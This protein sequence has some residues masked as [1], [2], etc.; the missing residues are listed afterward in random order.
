MGSLAK[1]VRTA[2]RLLFGLLGQHRKGLAPP[3]VEMAS[4]RAERLTA[5]DVAGASGAAAGA[6]RRVTD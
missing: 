6:G 1:Q 5:L 4:T 3:E 2:G